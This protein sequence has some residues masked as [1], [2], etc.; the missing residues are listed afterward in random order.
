MPLL[1]STNIYLLLVI[2]FNSNCIFAQTSISVDSTLNY[3]NE[4]LPGHAI[5][6]ENSASY[7]SYHLTIEKN[8]LFKLSEDYYPFGDAKSLM[9]S[10][11]TFFPKDVFCELKALGNILYVLNI[12][13]NQQSNCIYD[14]PS[15]YKEFCP[16]YF[17]NEAVAKS[18][19][20]AIN[21]LLDKINNNKAY[22]QLDNITDSFAPPRESSIKVSNDVI[23]TERSS[24]VKMEK[25]NGIY[26]VPVVIN[27]VLK[28]S[29]IFD[30]GASDVSISSD[31]ALTLIKTGTLNESDFIGSQKYRFADG[32]TATSK[33]FIIRELKIGNKTLKNVK[34]SISNSIDSPMLLGQSVLERFGTFTIDNKNHTIKIE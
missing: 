21:Y 7:H 5:V 12:N 19:Y 29:F 8:G 20:N 24:T 16:I 6:H 32:S 23:S 17:N 28:I 34:A 13:C 14:E 22:S 9:K 18:T 31:V 11:H 3:I 26:H 1:K 33:T 4:K 15:S 25:A 30:S 2:V 10:K 27:G